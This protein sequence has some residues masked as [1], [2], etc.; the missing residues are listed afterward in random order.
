MHED[1][2]DHLPSALDDA[3]QLLRT[4]EPV[5][6]AWRDRV[7]RAVAEDDTAEAAEAPRRRLVPLRAAVAAAIVCA[8]GGSAATI[9]MMR[10][11]RPAA[12]AVTM[13]PSRP[14]ARTVL[15]PVHFSVVAP[16]AASV[17]I[18]G[19]FNR[20]SPTALPMKRSA[21]GRTWEIDVELPQGRYNYSYLID[22]RIARDPSAPQTEGG[23]DDFG[24]PNS[25]LMVSGT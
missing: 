1:G 6:T 19:D 2:A 10:R 11:T 20:W 14:G 15:L 18:V 24:M 3:V 9:G 7:L 12:F 22:G 17:S 5:S 4:E 8:V 25:V 13:S 16:A 23:G 21:D